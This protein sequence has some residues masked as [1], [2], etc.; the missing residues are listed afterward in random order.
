LTSLQEIKGL[1][2]ANK[3]RKN[4]APHRTVCF[5][6][7]ARWPGTWALFGRSIFPVPQLVDSP[8]LREAGLWKEPL[9]I[10]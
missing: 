10:R 2:G 8:E 6:A 1:Q 3:N 7:A 4:L 9:V 5:W